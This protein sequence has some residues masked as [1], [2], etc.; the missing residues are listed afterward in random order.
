[1]NEMPIQRYNSPCAGKSQVCCST[2]FRITKR[3]F[4]LRFPENPN[5]LEHEAFTAVLRAVL[6]VTE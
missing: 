4:S 3:D 6:H 1:M 5:L 2:S